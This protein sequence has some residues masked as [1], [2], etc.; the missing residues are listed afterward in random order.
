[1]LF[2]SPVFLFAFLPL[3]L[4]LYYCSPL[5]LKNITLLLSSLLF[6]AWGEVFYVAIMVVSIAS[7]YVFGRLIHITFTPTLKRLWLIAGVMVNVLLLMAFKYANFIADNANIVISWLG[8]EAVL[9]E[10]VHL[11][12]GISFFTFQALSYIVDVYRK[13]VPS[14]RNIFNLALYISLFPQLIAGPIVRYHDVSAQIDGRVHSIDKFSSGVRRFIYGLAKKMLVANPLGEVADIVFALPPGE[15]AMPL[16]WIGIL[17]Y[18]LQIYFD[19]SGYSDMAIGLGRMFGFRFLENFNYPYVSR[20]VR[21]F[22]RRWHISLST[23][24]RDYVYIALGGNR[25]SSSRVYANL[26]VVFVLTGFWHGASWNFLVWGLFHG[27]FL[28]LE[29]AGFSR[30]LEK[31]PDAARHLYLLAI[32]IVGWIFFRVD[33]LPQAVAFIGAMGD[34]S[35]AGITPYRLAQVV[36]SEAI[37]AFTVGALLSFPVFPWLTQ[38]LHASVEG[39]PASIMFLRI[40]Q[41]MMLGGLLFLAVLK[42]ASSTYNPFIYFRF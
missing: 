42:M 31:M 28:M 18:T 14:Q 13:Q 11:P 24:F 19:F 2:S 40:P 36:S 16:A 29:H 20:S 21:E 17:T 34:I 25:L 35:S 15:L 39:N 9:L 37:L 5:W 4:V 7:N 26:L 30:V 27:T 33:S 23:W 22:W 3:V 38:R 32:V 41:F 6:Y 1:M 10:P 12:L 8:G